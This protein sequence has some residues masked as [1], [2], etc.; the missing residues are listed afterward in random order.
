MV[1]AR[2][3][4]G[5]RN[6]EMALVAGMELSASGAR[7]TV[8]L[9]GGTD[10]QDGYVPALDSLL[11]MRTGLLYFLAPDHHHHHRHTRTHAHT[12]AHTHTTAAA[13]S[14]SRIHTFPRS[15]LADMSSRY[16]RVRVCVRVRVRVRVC[17]RVCACPLARPTQLEVLA[18]AR[19]RHGVL[20]SAATRPAPWRTTT[21]TTCFRQ[22]ETFSPQG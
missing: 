10:G 19:C 18:T 11:T 12:H 1:C 13:P 7:D 5:G 21:R 8:I 6:Q 2:T 20:R 3:G 22:R 9:S 4:A 14:H 17:V 16:A 15:D